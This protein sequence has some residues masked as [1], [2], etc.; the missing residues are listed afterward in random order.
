MLFEIAANIQGR[1]QRQLLANARIV[2]EPGVYDVWAASDV[3]VKLDKAD[4][5]EGIAVAVS[6][7]NGYLIRAGTTIPLQVSSASSLTATGD[8]SYQKTD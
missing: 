6:S 4:N 3:Y 2:L 7:T 8:I 1:V 5:A